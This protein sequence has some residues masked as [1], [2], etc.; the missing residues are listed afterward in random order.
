MDAVGKPL[1][2]PSFLDKLNFHFLFP[3]K[4]SSDFLLAFLAC[5]SLF[6]FFGL[7]VLCHPWH[8]H[9]I[10]VKQKIIQF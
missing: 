1:L 4:N 8:F 3:R 2:G 5:C 9:G 7:F 10:Y 6:F